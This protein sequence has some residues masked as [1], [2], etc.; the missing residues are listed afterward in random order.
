MSFP[1][2]M[3]EWI[4]DRLPTRADAD[5]DEDVV[6]KRAPD[7]APEVSLGWAHYSVITPGQPWW[8]SKAEDAARPTPPPAP[9]PTRVVT[10]LTVNGQCLYAACNDCTIWVMDRRESAFWQQLPSIPQPEAS[11]A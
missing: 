9:A 10:A 5:N 1:T 8:S 11:N 4:T 2:T 3:A 7:R 6:I